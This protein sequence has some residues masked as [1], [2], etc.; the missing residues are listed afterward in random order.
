MG[1]EKENNGSLDVNKSGVQTKEVSTHKTMGTPTPNESIDI[2]SMS[3]EYWISVLLISF[4]ILFVMI[5][6]NIKTMFSDKKKKSTKDKN[7][8][9]K[10]NEFIEYKRFYNVS[11]YP[12]IKPISDVKREESSK[13]Q[14]TSTDNRN[15]T[16][17]NQL[18]TEEESLNNSLAS[19]FKN[20]TEYFLN[21]DEKLKTV[22]VNLESIVELIMEK[23]EKIKRYEEGYDQK[24]TKIFRK[25][26][27]ELI[28]FVEKEIEKEI[29][30]ESLAVILDELN[31]ILFN[32]GIEKLIIPENENYDLKKV[33]VV[34]KIPNDDSNYHDK[35]AKVLKNGYFLYPTKNQIKILRR[36]E[37]AIYI[38]Q[39][40]GIK[41][42]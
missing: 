17:F 35:V 38:N 19:Q 30:K 21:L 14:E 32:S 37:I 8:Q 5:S 31:S 29:E 2:N 11:P 27:F 1:I 6:P 22:N 24:N 3:S 28:D 25:D 40:K 12:S 16:N 20:Q 42:G 18:N 41:N 36:A 23:E 39:N 13:Q 9:K 33:S 10:D 4:L 7:I 26:I 15:D 34:K